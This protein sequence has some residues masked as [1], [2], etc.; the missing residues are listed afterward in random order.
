MHGASHLSLRDGV[1]YY[2]RRV[3]KKILDAL[4]SL[5]LSERQALDRGLRDYFSKSKFVRMSL[6]TRI[7]AVASMLTGCLLDSMWT[8]DS[9]SSWLVGDHGLKGGSRC[10]HAGHDTEFSTRLVRVTRGWWFS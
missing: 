9:D 1:Y 6:R 10:R 8:H 3:P 4:R 7:K 5:S 2:V